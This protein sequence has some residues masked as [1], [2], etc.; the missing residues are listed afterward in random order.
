MTY[1]SV[2]DPLISC[3]LAN[4]RKAAC[5]SFSIDGKRY[6]V[7]DEFEQLTLACHI[8]LAVG[9]VNNVNDR[10]AGSKFYVCIGEERRPDTS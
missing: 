3:L 4:T 5:F 9:A 8:I 6:F 2:I 10:L 1:S 7:D